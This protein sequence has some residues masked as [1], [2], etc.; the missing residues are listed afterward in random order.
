MT[1]RPIAIAAAA[2]GKQRDAAHRSRSLGPMSFGKQP[3]RTEQSAIGESFAPLTSALIVSQRSCSAPALTRPN[4]AARRRQ[5]QRQSAADNEL[6]AF[7]GRIF[8]CMLTRTMNE[9]NERDSHQT[10]ALVRESIGDFGLLILEGW[11]L[12]WTEKALS[13]SLRHSVGERGD[14]CAMALRVRACRR[15]R[16]P[17]EPLQ[18]SSSLT[19]AADLCNHGQRRNR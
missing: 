9:P 16:P 13:F 7:G 2:T 3:A 8:I 19:L 5:R 15:A 11:S 1:T 12:A 4:G 6:F 18:S 17:L 10:L 14:C